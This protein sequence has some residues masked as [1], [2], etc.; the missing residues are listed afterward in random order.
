MNK[1]LVSVIIPIYNVEQYLTQCVDSVLTQ[2]YQDIEIILVDDGSPDGSPLICDEFA[3]KNS[4]IKVIH[5]PNG[6]L[7]DA[8]NAGIE[9]SCGEYLFFL[10]ADDYLASK[11]IEELVAASSNGDLAIS[12]YMLD[13]SDEKKISDAKQTY[14]QYSSTVDFIKDFH[15]Y[16]ATKFNFAWGKLYRREIIQ[17]NHL[18]FQKGISLGEDIL[19]NLEYY[20]DCDKGIVAIPYNGYYYRQ[21]GSGTLSKKFNPKMFD[22]N[23]TCYMA[24]RDFLKEF[25]CYTDR[26]REHLYSNIVGNFQ[27]GFCLVANNP[28][29]S[30]H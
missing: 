9:A 4:C 27:Y 12:G 19:F 23:E 26:N 21:H 22:W 15:K 16:F 28:S 6:G 29:M 8:R 24:V 3:K 2:T 25:G 11:C 18:R 20:R 14:G 1:P 30:L 5:K 17:D 7:S 13:L 10:D